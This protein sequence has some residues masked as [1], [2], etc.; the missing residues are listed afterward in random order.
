MTRLLFR[1]DAYLREAPARV[2]G[3]TAEGGIELDASLFYPAGA[4]SRAM[5]AGWITTAANAPS[6]PP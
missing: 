4:A 6:P 1:D 5:P 3:H 2:T